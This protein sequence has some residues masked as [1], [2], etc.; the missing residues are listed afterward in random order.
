M[1]PLIAAAILLACTISRVN[2]QSQNG[3]TTQ[4]SKSV[5]STTKSS[6]SFHKKKGY[7]RRKMKPMKPN[8]SKAPLQQDKMYPWKDGQSATPTGHEATPIN[9]NAP[10]VKKDTVRKQG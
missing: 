6:H 5:A 2:A 9:G 7:H 4:K 3:A 10:A 8:L 1:K